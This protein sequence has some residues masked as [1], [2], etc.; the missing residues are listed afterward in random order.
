MRLWICF[1]LFGIA[2]CFTNTDEFK[3]LIIGEVSKQITASTEFEY[4]V[5]ILLQ[6]KLHKIQR[7]DFSSSNTKEQLMDKRAIYVYLQGLFESVFAEQINHEIDSILAIYHTIAP[8]SPMCLST[9]AIKLHFQANTNYSF[10]NEIHNTLNFRQTTVNKMM[11]SKIPLFVIFTEKGEKMRS[12][13]Q[14]DYFNTFV[15]NNVSQIKVIKYNSTNKVIASGATYLMSKNNQ[16]YLFSIN[17]SQINQKPNSVEMQITF[18][19]L[20]QNNINNL[21]P[22]LEIFRNNSK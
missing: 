11:K 2:Y 10:E 20:H 9:E 8:P 6:K 18:N 14:L 13:E 19:L 17:V 3:D 4:P 16:W 21:V 12:Q 5:K 1:S 7:S 22:I 15:R